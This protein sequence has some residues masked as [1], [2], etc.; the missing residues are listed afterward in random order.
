MISQKQ[1]EANRRNAL[2]ST[3][4]RTLRGKAISSLN[5]LSHCI[6]A[7]SEVLPDENPEDL[8]DLARA[9]IERWEPALQEERYLVDTL[10]RCDWRMRRFSRIEAAIWKHLR[11]QDSYHAHQA[12]YSATPDLN[13][14][15]I[16][17]SRGEFNRLQRRMD[18]THRTYRETLATLQ[19]MAQAAAEANRAE[20]ET[21]EP[22]AAEPESNQSTVGDILTIMKLRKSI[23]GSGVPVARESSGA[24]PP[25]LPESQ[26][27]ETRQIQ[28]PA[29]QNGFAPSTA[30]PPA[31]APEFHQ[32]EEAA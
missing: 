22:K 27:P 9:Y 24:C 11:C 19:V 26:E 2:K 17:R 28:R 23:L 13:G 7:E 4:P 15:A 1:L 8:R 20:E 5:P 6:Y 10:I 25:D 21:A 31:Q 18:S 32:V 30:K 16:E 12:P 14:L 29:G 3:G